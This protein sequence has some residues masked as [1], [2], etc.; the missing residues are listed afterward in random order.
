MCSLRSERKEHLWGLAVDSPG[1]KGNKGD[2]RVTESLGW[3]CF[4][5]CETGS[6]WKDWGSLRA[7][8]AQGSCQSVHSFRP[9]FCGH[10]T[11]STA[12]ILSQTQ[13]TASLSWG[14]L[15]APCPHNLVAMSHPHEPGQGH[16]WEDA[17]VPILQVKK[18]SL[19]EVTF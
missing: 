10:Q 16:G 6:S 15:A 14:C 3:G 7:P 17:S 12:T 19:A 2:C 9:P 11:R 4:T 5:L 1:R 18:L 13:S 8:K